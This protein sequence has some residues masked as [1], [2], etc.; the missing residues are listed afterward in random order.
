MDSR[1]KARGLWSVVLVKVRD[2]LL[3]F[4]RR[5]ATSCNSDSVHARRIFPNGKSFTASAMHPI[6]CHSN[7]CGGNKEKGRRIWRIGQVEMYR[8]RVD[9]R[10][11]GNDCLGNLVRSKVLAG[12]LSSANQPT[13]AGASV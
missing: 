12:K 8:S 6:G 13:P 10:G 3:A 1:A 11:G 4:G 2:Q 9:A 7:A 5:D